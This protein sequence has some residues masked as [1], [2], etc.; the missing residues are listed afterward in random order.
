MSDFYLRFD[1]KGD[2]YESA[3]TDE[4][5]PGRVMADYS[6]AG[7]LLG[8]E[9]LGAVVCFPKHAPGIIGKCIK[10][11]LEISQDEHGCLHGAIGGKLQA[12]FGSRYDMISASVYLCDNCASSEGW[13]A[14]AEAIA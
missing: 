12:G 6:A 3:K 2:D 13:E 11:K 10:C 5:I 9:V 8:I 4:L 14:I 7:E 1:V